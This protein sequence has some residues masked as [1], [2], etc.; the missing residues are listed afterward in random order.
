M[1]KVILL[2]K[3]FLGGWLDKEGNIGHEIID[4]LQTDRGDYYVYNNPWGIC[5]Q[6]IWIEGTSGLTKNSKEEY[7]AQYLLLTGSEHGKEFEILYV[8]ELEEKL[9]RHN[10]AKKE[11][12]KANFRMR[13]E[14]VKK[15][16]REKDIRYNGKYLDEIYGEDDSLYLTFKGKK[17][18]RAVNPIPVTDLEYNFQRNKGYIKDDKFPQD[19]LRVIT[20]IEES[21]K[22][23]ALQ[24]FTPRSVNAQQIGQVNANR[25]FLDLIGATDNEQVY[26]NIL[27][28]ILEQEDVLKHFCEKYKEERKFDSSGIFKVFRETKVISGRMDVCAESEKQRVII[29]NKVYSG[30]NGIRP[31]DDS[32]QL[33]TYVNNWGKSKE[34]EP[35]CF[36][37]VPNFRIGDIVREIAKRDPAMSNVYSIISYGAIADF[38]KEEFEAG[39]IPESYTYF[40][41]IPQIINAFKNLSYATKEDLYA[42][43]FLAATDR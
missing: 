5:P 19:Y 10:T 8:I 28:S 41:L 29:E 21:I 43:M 14:E 35:L 36:I 42:R 23:G 26:T 30:L 37:A 39:N 11:E 25:T 27:H 24:E 2:N 12:N 1:K 3:P 4:F 31:A 33:S 20:L 32:T 18:Y 34:M 17:I 16:M 6:D 13:Q 40:N 9:H 38:I 15:L 22:N 7:A